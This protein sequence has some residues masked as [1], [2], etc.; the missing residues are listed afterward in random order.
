[1]AAFLD[2]YFKL[3]ELQTNVRTEIIAGLSTY[4]SLAYILVLN[5]AILGHAGMDTSAILFATAIASGA[6]TLAMGLWA[7]L[8]FA[9]APRP[10]DERFFRLQRLWHFGDDLATR[11]RNRFLV[12]HPLYYPDSASCPAENYRLHPRWTENQYWC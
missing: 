6:A 4:L 1:M 2:H 3:D 5:P 8:P 12:R 10:G 11:V 9:V 7:K